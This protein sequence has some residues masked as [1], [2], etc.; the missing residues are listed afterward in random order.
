MRPVPHVR[1]PVLREGVWEA[2]LD[3]PRAGSAAP[4]RWACIFLS[5]PRPLS[6]SEDTPLLLPPDPGPRRKESPFPEQTPGAGGS[7]VTGP[8]ARPCPAWAAPP[9]HPWRTP[10]ARALSDS[11]KSHSAGEGAVRE[12]S[13]PPQS[14]RGPGDAR[15]R[16]PEPV[17]LPR[18]TWVLAAAASLDETDDEQDEHQE[19]DGT[20]EPDEPA[21]GGDVR[22][23]VGVSW[24]AG[25]GRSQHVRGFARDPARRERRGHVTRSRPRSC[26]CLTLPNPAALRPTLPGYKDQEDHS[27]A[28]V[29][30]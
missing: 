28:K 2:V 17:P 18:L 5:S 1:A 8:G 9:A 15:G 21:L 26:W 4:R 3:T 14:G 29:R 25:R 30:R 23:V 12:Q 7:G 19:G 24:G 13:P 11:S 6:G 10:S 16:S 22:L 20:H 27:G